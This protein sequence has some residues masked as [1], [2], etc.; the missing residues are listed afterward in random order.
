MTHPRALSGSHKIVP[1]PFHPGS[2]NGISE[3]LITSHHDHNYAAAVSSLNHVEA[4]LARI[5]EETAPFLVHGLGE[6]ELVFRNSKTLHEAYFK[7]LGGDGHASG[8]VETAISDTYGTIATWETTFKATGKS[9]GGGSGW[10]VLG[11]EYETGALRTFWSGNHSQTLASTAILMIM[12]MYEHAYQI[13][14]GADY[15]K[16][17][18]VFFKNVNWDEV[19][20]RYE[21]AQRATEVL[22]G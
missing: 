4:E 13:D 10:V 6:R 18:D 12:D 9:L 16:Y 2:L 14:F 17:I 20:R 15:E 11:Q 22:R 1:L 5:T 21:L 7:N 8:M 19:N 3:R